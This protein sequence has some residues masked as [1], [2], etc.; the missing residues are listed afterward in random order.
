MHSLLGYLDN[1]AEKI[2]PRRNW[3]SLTSC[4]V[5]DMHSTLDGMS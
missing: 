2:L 1:C 3:S 5:H 4:H